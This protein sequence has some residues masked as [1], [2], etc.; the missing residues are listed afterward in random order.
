MQKDVTDQL[1][2][3]FTEHGRDL[4]WREPGTSAWAILVCEAVR[5]FV[6]EAL[7]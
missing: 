5:K 3:W 2:E 7:I 6:C 1:I 4:P